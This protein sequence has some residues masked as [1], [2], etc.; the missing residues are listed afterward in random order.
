MKQ[1]CLCEYLCIACNHSDTFLHIPASIRRSIYI[2]AGLT[3]GTYTAWPSIGKIERDFYCT[4]TEED[5]T[6]THS[7]TQ[8][9]RQIRNEVELIVLGENTLVYANSDTD[10]DVD[11]G[12]RFLAGLS[13]FACSLLKNVHVQLH[14]ERDEYG[15]Y[16]MDPPPLCWK[17]IRL[18]VNACHNIL[19][20]A[21]P[22][23]LRLHLICDTGLSSK[24]ESVLA[25]FSRYPGMLLELELRLHQ[26]D[27]KFAQGPGHNELS[28]L[29]R[30]VGLRA[31]G[32]DP[33]AC[34][35]KPFRFFDL[36]VEI[37]RNVFEYTNL[38]TPYRKVHWTAENGFRVQF[39]FCECDGSVC[40]EENLHANL[41]FI[42]CG[43]NSE[44]TEEYCMRRHSS[45]SPRCKH[46]FSPLSLFL[47]S[48]AM[49]E[50]AIGFFYTS[51]RV[52]VQP[53][54]N[55]EN[56]IFAGA[57]A[58]SPFLQP[59]V[60]ELPEATDQIDTGELPRAAG[61]PTPEQQ[62]DAGVQDDVEQA[63]YLGTEYMK[64]DTTKLFISRIGSKGLKLLRSLEII[65]PRIGP[66]SS[67]SNS[68]AAYKEWCIAVEYLAAGLG[69]SNL[70]LTVHIW[71]TPAGQYL[72]WPLER[73]A[74]L[75]EE[76]APRLLEPLRS[77][78]QLQRLFVH[79]EWPTHWAPPKLYQDIETCPIPKA[80]SSGCGIGYN[81]IP[82][83]ND[84]VITKE[85][86]LEK[87]VMGR[88]YD[89]YSVGKGDELPSQWV[90]GQW[91]SMG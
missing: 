71:T 54:W 82:R 27:I 72:T 37:R 48:R 47:A 25:P 75:L 46:G 76:H 49:Y 63:E 16:F 38:V 33:N 70:T 5:Y 8:V 74:H 19:T 10:N 51:N 28:A 1:T 88:E 52:V 80:P 53:N 89:S 36:P 57:E 78:T 4:T 43:A 85:I 62:S 87:M 91:N 18:W 60:T 17:R 32:R 34:P 59:S 90:R 15:R 39:I 7:L 30:K 68:D 42:N 40:Q 64:Y 81:W 21:T 20:H 50:E 44:V 23:Q 6:I 35:Q 22:Q 31:Q 55:V 2:Y 29:A 77:V 61:H 56:V 26:H 14:F 73:T 58:K 67:L 69:V 84:E 86:R 9:C 24:T 45:Y 79:L 41:N 65:F 3:V 66:N 83:S 11:N 13:P 12:L